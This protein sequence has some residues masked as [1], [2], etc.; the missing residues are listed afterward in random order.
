MRSVVLLTMLWSGLVQA[1]QSDAQC[2][3]ALCL[4]GFNPSFVLRIQ[5]ADSC[6]LDFQLSWQHPQPI[7]VCAELAG[8]SLHCWQQQT[9]GRLQY[10]AQLDGPGQ[11]HLLVD[12]K[13]ASVPAIIGF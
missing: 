1:M 3:R 9:S 13:N 7:S 11:L 12:G 5:T 4:A 10:Q 6:Q 2:D 8:Q